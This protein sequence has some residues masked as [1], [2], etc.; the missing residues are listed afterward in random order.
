M[1]LPTT[2][3]RASPAWPSQAENT[4]TA[5]SGALVPERY[6]GQPYHQRR[7]P[8]IGGQLRRAAYQQFGT[9]D[10]DDKACNKH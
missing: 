4:L 5:S 2:L 8:Q 10:E 9:A 3:P 7:N 6:D 1:L